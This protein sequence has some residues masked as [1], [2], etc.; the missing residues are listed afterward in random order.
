MILPGAQVLFNRYFLPWHDGKIK[1]AGPRPGTFV[2]KGGTGTGLRADYAGLL[3][4]YLLETLPNAARDAYQ[5]IIAFTRFDESVLSAVDA[6]Y[7]EQK[8]TAL[9]ANSDPT[10]FA[11]DY[12]TET[13]YY[14]A[15]LSSLFLQQEGFGWLY[16]HPYFYSVIV[17]HASGTAIPV[18]DWALRRFSAERLSCYPLQLHS[19]GNW[20]QL[21]G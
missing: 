6:Y 19:A 5:P 13:S 16:E 11:N 20:Q 9:I 3:K 8:V 18:F 21:F 17:H 10:D 4:D 12:L 1:P 15:M 14:A 7:D 2:V